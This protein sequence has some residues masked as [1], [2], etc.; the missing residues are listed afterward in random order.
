MTDPNPPGAPQTNS[1][2]EE[3]QLALFANLI[4]QQT[5]MAMMFMGK[6]PH[7]ESGKPV[8]DLEGASMFIDTLE[9]LA[10][11][12]KGNLSPREEQVL[13]QSLMSVRMAFV[14]ASSGNASTP[15]E[16]EK[17]TTTTSSETPATPATEATSEAGKR[18][19]DA[20]RKKFVKK[21]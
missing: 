21:Y 3:K 8:T 5:N 16:P 14:E 4:L 6:T 17:Q 1:S 11:K 10:A 19:D 20:D 9:M 2:P 18:Q 15:A 13:Q 7:P 12:T